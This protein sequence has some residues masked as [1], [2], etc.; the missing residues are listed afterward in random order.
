GLTSLRELIAAKVVER[1]GF[2][3]RPDEV[4]VTTGA[5]G[6]LHACLLALL[7]PGDELLVPDPGWTTM[8][9]M[10]I[11]AGVTPV[12]YALDRSRGFALDPGAV[13]A[14]IGPR[15][16]AI[17]VNSPSNPTGAVAS[18]E[19]LAAVLG[20]AARHGLWLISDECYEELVFDGE[21]VSPA[22]LGERERVISV[23]SFSKSYAM[24][25]WRVGYLTAPPAVARLIAKAQEPIVSSAST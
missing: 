7:D 9:P 25:G 10:S 21:H 15:T 13:E 23:F 16:R 6:G 19:A 5:C 18:R 20:L 1:N 8:V 12:G 17:V 24:T 11:A 3:C 22:A 2:E 14:R 4:V